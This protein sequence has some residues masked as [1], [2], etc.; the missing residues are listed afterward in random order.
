MGGGKDKNG[1]FRFLSKGFFGRSIEDFL[2]IK[3]KKFLIK[4]HL[5]FYQM[6][7]RIFA[8]LHDFTFLTL[9][10]CSQFIKHSVKS[11]AFLHTNCSIL[12][13]LF[14]L[15]NTRL[16]I[17]LW[18]IF[19]FLSIFSCLSAC[20]FSW[21]FSFFLAISKLFLLVTFFFFANWSLNEEKNVEITE[22]K[23]RVGFL[24]PHQRLN[25]FYPF[26]S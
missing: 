9:L 14:R 13:G 20:L 7:D 21:S 22:I 4:F 12:W 25:A 18:L 19:P 5:P 17:G 1:R 10:F 2:P 11:E 26:C 6:F 3:K 23:K 24:F 8:I 15:R 16:L